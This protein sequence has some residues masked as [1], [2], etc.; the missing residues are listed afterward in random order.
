MNKLHF[1]IKM[2]KLLSSHEE[3]LLNLLK[4]INFR[5]SIRKILSRRG[6]LPQLILEKGLISRF[7]SIGWDKYIKTDLDKQVT[8]NQMR[9]SVLKSRKTF[10]TRAKFKGNLQLLF[11]ATER[12]SKH[13][14]FPEKLFGQKDYNQTFIENINKSASSGYPLFKKKGLIASKLISDAISLSLNPKHFDFNDFPSTV[15]FRTQLRKSFD[16]I[17]VKIRI[18]YP[19]TGAITL[20]ESSFVSPFIEHFQTVKSFYAIGHT[21]REM[22]NILKNNFQN[23]SNIIS[24][25]VDSYDQNMI[26]EVIIMAFYILRKQLYLTKFQEILFENCMLYF[27]KS[28][29]SYK[30]GKDNVAFYIKQKGIPSGSTFTNLI[31]TLCHAIIIEYISPNS[32]KNNAQI[33]SDDNI[34]HF[35]GNLKKL[36]KTYEYAFNLVISKQK[37]KVYKDPRRLSFLGYIWLNYNRHIDPILALNQCVWHSSF[38]KDLD[39]YERELARCASTLLNGKNGIFLFKRLFPDVMNNLRKNRNIKFFYLH[40]NVPPLK[41]LARKTST[42]DQ[43]ESLRLHLVKGYDIR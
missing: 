8:H 21:G 42:Y 19:I 3:N 4:K 5:K 43:I 38:R 20:I 12:V 15:G 2:N 36:V 10:A 9:L 34:F 23:S 40:D 31:G 26:N 29:V 35:S 28:I 37:T 41:F 7:K 27:M 39:K 32:T 25:D 1:F 6:Y 17:L 14:N 18:M 13:C 11:D 22:G 30:I 24:L 16:K 33:C